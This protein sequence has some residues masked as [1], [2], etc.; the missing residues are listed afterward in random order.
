[1]EVDHVR[2]RRAARVIKGV[3]RDASDPADSDPQH[4]GVVCP[5]ADPA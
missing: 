3:Y 4:P 1:V 5:T 2:N